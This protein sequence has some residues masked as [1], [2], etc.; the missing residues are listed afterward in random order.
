LGL[1]IV[2]PCFLLLSRPKSIRSL[3]NS[4]SISANPERIIFL[5]D[6]LNSHYLLNKALKTKRLIYVLDT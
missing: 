1:P 6:F 5:E 2:L 3:I 4:L